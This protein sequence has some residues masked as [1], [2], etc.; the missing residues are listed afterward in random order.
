M[1]NAEQARYW[2]KEAETWR[3][4]IGDAEARFEAACRTGRTR[5]SEE[6]IQYKV[7]AASKENFGYQ[8]AARKLEATERRATMYALF[9]LLDEAEV[10]TATD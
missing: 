6:E 1:T 4:R 7:Y 3:E 2:L 10:A 8:R 9:A 5:L